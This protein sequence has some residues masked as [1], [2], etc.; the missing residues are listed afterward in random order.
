MKY[1]P[2]CCS[3]IMLSICEYISSPGHCAVLQE[4]V[5]LALPSQDCPPLIGGGLSHALANTCCPPP[6][7][8]EQEVL[9]AQGPHWPSSEKKKM[10]KWGTICTRRVFSYLSRLRDH[11][12]H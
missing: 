6:Q 5:L 8:T 12:H 10:E 7:V 9:G 11:G 3:M 1:T 4:S 2:Q